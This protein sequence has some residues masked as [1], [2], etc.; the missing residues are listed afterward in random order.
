MNKNERKFIQ[1]AIVYDWKI[2][3]VP[4]RK[5]PLWEGDSILPVKVGKICESLIEKGYLEKV[6][7]GRG[8]VTIRATNKAKALKCNAPGCCKGKTV[9][10]NGQES[11]DCQHCE[12][13]VIV[14]NNS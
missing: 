14:Q 6:D 12:N 11:G 4:W 10:E 7:M 5:I 3:I 13:G 2:E 9:D 1:P 8:M